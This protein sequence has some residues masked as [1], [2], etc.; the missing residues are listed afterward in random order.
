MSAVLRDFSKFQLHQQHTVCLLCPG[1]GWDEL[2]AR[3][4]QKLHVQIAMHHILCMFLVAMAR[5]SFDDSSIHCVLL[6]L[7]MTSFSVFQIGIPQTIHLACFCETYSRRPV[8]DFRRIRYMALFCLTCFTL[9]SC[10]TAASCA[11]GAKSAIYSCLVYNR[12]NVICS[13]DY[14]C[15][16]VLSD[17]SFQKPTSVYAASRHRVK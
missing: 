4:S 14:L 11:L 3:I 17:V 7:W 1:Q 16:D 6:V 13:S 5:S 15:W 9:S 10:T 8:I 2:F 12:L